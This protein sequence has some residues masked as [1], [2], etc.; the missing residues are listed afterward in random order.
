MISKRILGVLL[1]IF[2]LSLLYAYL[3]TPKQLRISKSEGPQS[4]QRSPASTDKMVGEDVNRTAGYPRLRVDLLERRPQPY[5]GV[6][7]NLFFSAVENPPEE[8]EE[9]EAPPIVV[10]PPVVAPVVPPSDPPPPTA[11]EVARQE[12]SQ[13]KFLGLFQ[14]KGR[15]TIF[16]SAAG[17]VFL[18][19]KGDYLGR[20]RK[21]FVLDITE[22]SL[23]LRREGTGEIS[24]K[25]T[26]QETL[27]TITIQRQKGADRI[28]PPLSDPGTTLPNLNQPESLA[29]PDVTSIQGE[30]LI[31]EEDK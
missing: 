21:Y 12:L 25:L 23:L 18:V 14:K 10:P 5:P 16:L 2:M 4:Q 8:D 17:E 15:Q 20:D 1:L 11:Q 30:Q 13:Y 31:P 7:R 9:I 24:I 3:Q 27:S 28:S 6:R 22:T 29:V 19:R 26:D